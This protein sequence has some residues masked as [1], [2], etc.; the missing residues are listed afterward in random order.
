LR[1]EPSS[2]D[3]DADVEVGKLIFAQ[4]ENGLEGFKTEAFWLKVLDGL[5]V[6]LDE[7][8]ALLGKSAGRC[9]LFPEVLGTKVN[10]QHMV[11]IDT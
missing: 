8:A 10:F 4:D 11:H 6:H 9:S 7:T 3:S 5:T 2:F 1:G